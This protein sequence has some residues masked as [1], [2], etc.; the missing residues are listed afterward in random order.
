MS[1][2]NASVVTCRQLVKAK[3][4]APLEQQ[5]ELDG[6]IALNAGIWRFAVGMAIDIGLH[7]C[8]LEFLGQVENVVRNTKLLRYSSSVVNI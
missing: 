3:T 7:D 8:S 2:N 1:L 6:P 4:T 5:F